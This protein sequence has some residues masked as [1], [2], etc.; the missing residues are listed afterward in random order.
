MSETA[1]R[2]LI[3]C[4]LGLIVWAALLAVTGGFA[5]SIASLKIASR[6][7]VRPL[8]LG[9]LL[10]GS[11]IAVFG[12]RQLA[13][14]LEQLFPSL[15][16]GI[17]PAMIA[18]PVAVFAF[19]VWFGTF[20]ASGA[21]SYGYV[22]QADLWLRLALRVQQPFV[23]RMPWPF[24]D[25]T[26]AP[27]G[28]R[29]GPDHSIV[30][31]YPPGL[32]ILMAAFKAVAGSQGPYLVV[33]I[34]GALCVWLCYELGRRA[35]SPLVGAAAALVFASSP[36]FLFQLVWP[37]SAIPAAAFCTAAPVATPR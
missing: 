37:M 30:P 20:A 11:F 31:T 33:P 29:P 24:A 18:I 28:Y 19:G 16:I 14:N 12:W 10:V 32:P 1:R 25:W 13:S 6:D 7:P 27:L 3:A 36:G 21:D 4:A 35:V 9:L 34:V 26:F 23:E 17:A 5:V 15:Q 2:V 8:V 22:S